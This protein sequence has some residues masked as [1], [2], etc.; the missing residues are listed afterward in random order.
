[1]KLTD[2]SK[3]EQQS[4]LDSKKFADEFWEKTYKSF[5]QKKSGISEL[6]S[7]MEYTNSIDKEIIG[8]YGHL[9]IS[10]Y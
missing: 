8:K 10:R 1:M 2:Y 4:A 5:L 7:A 6:I 9:D 3:K